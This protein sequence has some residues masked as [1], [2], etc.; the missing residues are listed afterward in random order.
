LKQLRERLQHYGAMTLSNEELLCIILLTT[1]PA[2]G[3]D[4]RERVSRLL[5]SRGG[6]HGLMRADF[7]DLCLEG[8]LGPAKA[9]QVQAVCELAKRFA[10]VDPDERR[11]VVSADDAACLLRPMMMHL[12]QE[13][14]RVLVLDIKNQVVA[15]LHLYTGT[16]E[17]SVLRAA[18]IFRPAIARNCPR[19]IVA[20]NHPSGVPEPS[21]EDIEVTRQLVEAGKLLDIE[22]I[23]HLILGN[24]NYVS[25][26]ERMR[27]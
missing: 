2:H 27:W 8:Q 15:N 13:T 1:S 14:L 17:S 16:V 11:R 23:D 21:L 18:E 20:H 10:L 6:L 22:V 3:G 25:L 4:M 26:R 19:L 24:P 9:A 5:A 7:G 12:E